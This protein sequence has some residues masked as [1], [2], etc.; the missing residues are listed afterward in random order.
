MKIIF[1]KIIEG[2]LFLV[3][4]ILFLPMALISVLFG[5]IKHFITYLVNK[6]SSRRRYNEKKVKRKLYDRIE[7]MLCYRKEIDICKE[8]WIPVEEYDS[9]ITLKYIFT[10]N[11]RSFIYRKDI[12]KYLYNFYDANAHKDGFVEKW[13]EEIRNMFDSDSYVLVEDA[14]VENPYDDTKNRN[15]LRIISY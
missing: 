4:G 1:E 7:K 3:M 6:L 2:T 12:D 13:I 8:F 5:M 10:G 11:K 9:C 14:I 15:V